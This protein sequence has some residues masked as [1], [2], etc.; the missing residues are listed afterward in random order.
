MKFN[1]DDDP[2]RP[3]EIKPFQQRVIPENELPV[4]VYSIFALLLGMLGLM[5]R[6][7]YYFLDNNHKLPYRKL[8]SL[9][10]L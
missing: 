5:T 1:T 9:G 7:Y 10:F 4:D 3:G 2:R 8:F 6:V